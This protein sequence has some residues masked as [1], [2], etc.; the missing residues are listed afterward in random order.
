MVAGITGR[1]LNFFTVLFGWLPHVIGAVLALVVGYVVARVVGTL[2]A[3]LLHRAGLDR[4]LQ[5]GPAAALLRKL[6]ATPSRL[7]GTVAFWAIMLGTIGVAADILGVQSIKSFVG[8]VYAYLPNVAAA[9]AIFVVAALLAGAVT[10]FVRRVAGDTALGKIA[11]TAA[12]ILIMSIATFMMLNQLRIASD[13]VNITYAAL[14]GSIG[15]GTAIAFGLGG[16]D[17]AQ[18]TLE[19]AVRKAQS[20]FDRGLDQDV[21]RAQERL[22]EVTRQANA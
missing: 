12:P 13:I 7:L 21:A 11:G 9:L 10:G 2:V 16:R 15:L 3:R 19:G 20:D 1:L 8:R 17:L 4:W 14:L 5:S 6:T 18:Q 22:D